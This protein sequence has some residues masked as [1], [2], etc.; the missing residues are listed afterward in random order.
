MCPGVG[1]Q[2]HM[3][4]LFSFLKNLHP[5]FY[6]GCTNLHSHQR[7]PFSSHPL[8]NFF[9]DFLMRAILT[10]VRWYLVVVLICISLIISNDEQLVM[11]LWPSGCLLLVKCLFR[12]SAYFSIGVFVILLLSCLCI[13]YWSVCVFV[14]MLFVYFGNYIGCIVCKYEVSE[15]EWKRTIPFKNISKRHFSLWLS[16]LRTRLVSTRMQV[17]SLVL[18]SGLRIR[19]CRELWCGS[20]TRLGSGIAVA[21]A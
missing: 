21:I 15:G 8:Q 1:L 14:T 19:H 17:W 12:S 3:E 2:D 13:C 18:I 10:G 4:T 6:S 5:V 16:Q 11:C 20:G 9:V 7:A